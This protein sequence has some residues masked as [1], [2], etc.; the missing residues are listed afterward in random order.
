V[1]QDD[2]TTPER[3][4]IDLPDGSLSDDLR[5]FLGDPAPESKPKPTRGP[6]IGRQLR[7][8]FSAHGP[9]R[10]PVG[11][12]LQP[13]AARPDGAPAGSPRSDDPARRR[14][15]L[16]EAR[17]DAGALRPAQPAAEGGAGGNVRRRGR[18]PGSGKKPVTAS[19]PAAIKKL[20][21]KSDAPASSS[22][23]I[24]TESER[25][26][27]RKLFREIG[28]RFNE[29][30][31]KSKTAAYAG[32]RHDLMDNLDTLVMG[33]AIDLKEATTIITNLE[34]YTRETEQESTE[35]PATILGRW[36]RMDAAEV[37]GLTVEVVE[38]GLVAN[39]SDE[40]DEEEA[41]LDVE[42]EGEFI[43]S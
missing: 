3:S 21:P 43:L 39:E 33:G 36:L 28:Q 35:T 6:R 16:L 30:R 37:A 11:S 22:K 5:S 9:D 40:E 1:V 12:A 10:R 14:S 31:K 42:S 18:P 19:L 8:T 34:Q 24:P 2:R 15:S 27:A 26:D 13:A 23:L 4:Y 7:A 32:F 38:D 17:G 41:S 20:V 29:N 25:Q